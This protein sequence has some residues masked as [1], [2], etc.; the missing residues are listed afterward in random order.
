[1][2]TTILAQRLHQHV[3]AVPNI[4]AT[5]SE[6]DWLNRKPEKWSKKEIVGHLADSALYN[7][8]RFTRILFE[9]QPYRLTPY[10]QDELVKAN[11]Y[12]NQSLEQL[13][14][15]WSVLNQQILHV[16]STYSKDNLTLSV[17]DRDKEGSLAWWMQDY[18]EHLE[19]H[20]AQI[21]A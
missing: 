1:M 18:I 17:I 4:V 7:L 13:L 21:K 11:D 8:E 2:P 10:P 14:G 9:P 15:L 3:L 12:Q 19:H 6:R 5:I 20:L 16:W